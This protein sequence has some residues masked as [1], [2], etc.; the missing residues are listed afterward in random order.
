[1]GTQLANETL[2]KARGDPL[3]HPSAVELSPAPQLTP[4][5]QLLRKLL[6][7]GNSYAVTIPD[8][9]VKANVNPRFP[10]LTTRPNPD[11]TITLAPFAPLNPSTLQP[12]K[13]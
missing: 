5:F 4:S 12:L 1:L 2:S 11:G 10:Y 9:W 13:R 6:H 8:V 3:P 7:L